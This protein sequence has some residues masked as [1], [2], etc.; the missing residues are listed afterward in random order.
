MH[1]LFTPRLSLTHITEQ[2]WS[3]FLR[4]QQDPVVMRYVS[5]ERKE[6]DIR[7]IFNSRLVPWEMHSRHWLCLA[8]RDK[9]NGTPI[10]F[11]GFVRSEDDIAEV[12]FI[13]DPVFHGQG[14]GS[15][16]LQTVCQFA[17]ETCAIRKLTAT[18]T[19]GNIG[20]KKVLEK[21]GFQP[22]G[23]LRENYFLA[24]T[25]QDDWIFGLLRNEFK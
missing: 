12:G 9:Y 11:T 15:E 2:D 17:F 6:A 7:Q 13:L 20:S 21:V 10:G 1:P 8:M 4:L 22:E 25:W 5:D 24:G 19:V 23:I 3:L 16:S 18:V 14:Y